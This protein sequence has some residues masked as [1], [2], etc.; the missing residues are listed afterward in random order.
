MRARNPLLGHPSARASALSCRRTRSLPATVRFSVDEGWVSA[1]EIPDAGI[2]LSRSDAE[3]PNAVSIVPFTGDVFA[4]ACNSRDDTDTVGATARDFAVWL[5]SREDVEAGEPLEVEV[6]GRPAMQVDL[7]TSLPTACTDPPWIWLWVVPV[8][9]DFHFE[10]REKARVTA[11][12]A[13]GGTIVFVAEAFPDVDYESFLAEATTLMES[14][15]FE[16]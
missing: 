14:V 8:V 15:E 10:D 11:V 6:G 4:K 9:N 2:Q 3:G 12:D 13:P 5:A 16:E 1:E 7:T